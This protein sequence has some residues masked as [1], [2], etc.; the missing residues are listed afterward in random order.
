MMQTRIPL[1]SGTFAGVF[2]AMR[3]LVE[4][5]KAAGLDETL[6]HLIHMRASQIN[7]CGYCLDMHSKD[8]R[9]AG[10]TEQRLHVLPAWREAPFYSER[11]RA[12]LAWTEAVTKLVDGHVPDDVYSQAAAVFTEPEL[13]A[14]TLTI[15]QINGWNRICIAFNA[16]PGTYQ[17]GQHAA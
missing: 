10:E 2:R 5:V 14:L 13:A 4:P 8:A 16:V 11:E 7:G 6:I 9:A 17:V 12:A 15:V 1:H 3:G